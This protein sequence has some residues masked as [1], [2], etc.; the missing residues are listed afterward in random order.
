M[1]TSYD[2][3]LS[4]G[5]EFSELRSSAI[6]KAQEI[7]DDLDEGMVIGLDAYDFEYKVVPES[8]QSSDELFEIEH[9]TPTLEKNISYTP[10]L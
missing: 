9:I 1:Q 5:P 4:G 3:Y 10:P 7:A 8:C 2:I 6:K